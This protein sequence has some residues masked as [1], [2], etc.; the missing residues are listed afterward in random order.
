MILFCHLLT[1][2]FLSQPSKKPVYFVLTNETSSYNRIAP[3]KIDRIN[4]KVLEYDTMTVYT[5]PCKDGTNNIQ[6]VSYKKK[7]LIK[8]NSFFDNLKPKNC[9]WMSSH[10]E[11][12]VSTNER[13]PL[14]GPIYVVEKKANSKAIILTQ[15]VFDIAQ[16]RN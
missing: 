4:K 9:T 8:S 15:V 11:E 10:I 7:R 5:L 6:L 14:I 12:I 1:L 2:L 13:S 3:S 16:R